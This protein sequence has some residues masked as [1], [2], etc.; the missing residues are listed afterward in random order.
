[1]AY[2]N[3]DSKEI[4]TKFLCFGPSGSGKTETFRSFLRQSSEDI[5]EGMLELGEGS[6]EFSFKF[7]PISVGYIKDFHLKLHLFIPSQSTQMYETVEKVM[8][9]GVDGVLFTFDSRLKSMDRNL[10]AFEEA[11]KRIEQAKL[12]FE[13]LSTVFQ[14]NHK[15]EKTALAVKDMDRH[16][17]HQQFASYQTCAKNDEG[18]PGVLDE[19]SKMVIKK[20]IHT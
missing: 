18:T 4:H 1:M 3:F 8:F 9:S 2:V 19:I 16:L 20:I 6:K 15:D 5:Q 11:S 17:N 10:V 12:P 14:Y 13:K 7:L